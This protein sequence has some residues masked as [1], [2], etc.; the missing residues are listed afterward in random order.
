MF[1]TA[2]DRVYYAVSVVQRKLVRPSGYTLKRIRPHVWPCSKLVYFLRSGIARPTFAQI[3][4]RNCWV[5]DTSAVSACH[6][7]LKECHLA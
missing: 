5:Y 3:S 2:I 6:L 7:A 4:F 1:C